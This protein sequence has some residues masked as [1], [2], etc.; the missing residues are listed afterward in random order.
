MAGRQ[1]SFPRNQSFFALDFPAPRRGL[2]PPTLV[3]YAMAST[4]GPAESAIGTTFPPPPAPA[5]NA[6]VAI[7]TGAN[8][9]IGLAVCVALARAGY[10]VYGGMRATASAAELL[11]AAAAAAVDPPGA[12]HVVRMDV[13]NDRSVATAVAAVLAATGDRVDVAVANAGYG[14]R[15]TVEGVPLSDYQSMMN[16]NFFGA[17]RLV[18][19]CVPS[20]RRRRSG[21]VL[22]VSS[23]IGLVAFPFFGAYAASKFAMEGLWESSHAE[24][25]ALGVHFILVRVAG[26]RPCVVRRLGIPVGLTATVHSHTIR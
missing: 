19:A 24:Y 8:S 26:G 12:V 10:T 13:G 17:L 4:D 5:A 25:K 11:A 15:V 18:Q 9:G 2:H 22:G 16:V 6:P 20:M 14:K 21:R 23:V 7:V 1:H 3:V